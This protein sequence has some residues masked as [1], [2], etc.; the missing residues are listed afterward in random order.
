MEI[1]AW[2]ISLLIVVMGVVNAAHCGQHLF[3]LI[4]WPLPVA[5]ARTAFIFVRRGFHFRNG[6]LVLGPE[7]RS[8]GR[9]S[10]DQPT[11]LS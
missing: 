10:I 4:V 5:L 2:I 3:W 7:A 8:P 11:R 1:S 6:V 9:A